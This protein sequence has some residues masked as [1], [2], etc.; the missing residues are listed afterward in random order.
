[1]ENC[2]RKCSSP[3]KRRLHHLQKHGS[4]FNLAKTS[5]A[6]NINQYQQQQH[7]HHHHH[8]NHA[9]FVDQLVLGIP[10]NLWY[11][12]FLNPQYTPKPPHSV[13]DVSSSSSVLSSVAI[14]S[15]F[16]STRPSTTQTNSTISAAGSSDDIMD[17][18]TSTMNILSLVPQSVRRQQKKKSNAMVMDVDRSSYQSSLTQ[19]PLPVYHQPTILLDDFVHSTDEN[20]S[21]SSK[22]TASGKQLI[23]KVSV[24]NKDQFPFQKMDGG[25]CWTLAVVSRLHGSNVPERGRENERICKE[26]MKVNHDKNKKS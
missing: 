6:T 24:L 16:T 10:L 25:Q 18:L 13:S 14:L 12:I 8:L 23:K 11:E 4:V 5:S 7:Y 1:L 19:K 3:F 21:L 2:T 20:A 15:S 26:A 22:S 9:K 17:S